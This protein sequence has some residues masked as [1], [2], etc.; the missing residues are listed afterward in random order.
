MPKSYPAHVRE[1]MCDRLIAGESLAALHV[2]SGVS[3]ATLYLWKKQA[4]IDAGARPGV[5]SVES[6]HLRAARRRIA[7]LE[8]ELRLVRDASEL[9]D[10]SA[11]VPPKDA[12]PWP[13]GS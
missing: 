9:F 12:K 4:L 13:K 11:V 2:E 7:D 8:D 10:A 5:D 3:A 1:R 6:S